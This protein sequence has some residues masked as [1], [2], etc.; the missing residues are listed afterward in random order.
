M[1]P[2]VIGGVEHQ[3]KLLKEKKKRENEADANSHG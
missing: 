3:P 1:I 2:M